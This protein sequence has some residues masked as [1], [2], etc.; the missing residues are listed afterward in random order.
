[1]DFKIYY[2]SIKNMETKPEKAILDNRELQLIGF[3]VI[4]DLTVWLKS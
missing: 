3:E 2:S 1:M 4:G